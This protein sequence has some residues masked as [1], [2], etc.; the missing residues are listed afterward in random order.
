ME[1]KIDKEI[2]KT[3]FVDKQLPTIF[4]EKQ[5]VDSVTKSESIVIS[6]SDHTSD[7]AL[8]TFEKIKEG[9]K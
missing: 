1:K 6:V 4:Y 9:L 2:H 5:K 3:E 8:K 7:K